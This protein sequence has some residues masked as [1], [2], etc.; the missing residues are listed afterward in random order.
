[1]RDRIARNVDRVGVDGIDQRRFISAVTNSPIGPLRVLGVCI[2]WHMAEVTYPVDVKRKPWELHIRYL[3][4]LGELLAKTDVPTVVAGDFNQA[5]PRIKYGNKAAAVAM[6]AAF[7]PF[8]IVTR[9]RVEGGTRAG[10]DH[11]AISHHV[12]PT[13]VWGWPN[14]IDGRRLSDHDGAGVDLT[15]SAAQETLPQPTGQ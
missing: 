9:G 8:E 5:I 12:A 6:D 11:I 2:P 10:I 13:K 14:E 7:A 3:E 4:L 1:M 15:T